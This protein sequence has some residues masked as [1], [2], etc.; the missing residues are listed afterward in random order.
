MGDLEIGKITYPVL[1]S[2]KRKP[3]Y[4]I[5]NLIGR[6]MTYEEKE[7]ITEFIIDNGGVKATMN[8]LKSYAE[9]SKECL[10]N[11][12][13]TEPS[14]V[15]FSELWKFSDL[16]FKKFEEIKSKKVA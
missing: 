5:I 15:E 1:V 12:G 14:L 11:E 6:Q 10:R 3:E 7:S 2:L 13:I 4:Y 8:L 9:R 16:P